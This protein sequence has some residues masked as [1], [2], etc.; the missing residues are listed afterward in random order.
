MLQIALVEDDEE[1]RSVYAYLI[2]KDSEMNAHP[3][4][5]SE[6][7]LN[8]CKISRFDIVIM[9]VNLPGMDGITCTRNLK[10]MSPET[11]VLMFTVYENN[12][13]IFKALEAGASGYLVKQSSPISIIGAIRELYSGGAPMSG[14]IA[15]KVLDHFTKVQKPNSNQ[16]G[17]S[18]REQ[19]ILNL[20]ARG[21]R[22]QDIAD[23]L[24]ISFGTVR[25]HIYNIYTKMHVDNRT[26]ALNKWRDGK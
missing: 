1:I 7:F 18:E 3:F 26:E 17:L 14:Q 4:G 8:A 20:L 24:Y 25:T 15:R 22:Y 5:D 19:E 6:S 9:D 11:L 13:N 2:N 21:Y 23:Q 12:E 16:F 10:A